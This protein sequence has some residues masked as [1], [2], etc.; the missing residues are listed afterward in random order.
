MAKPTVGIGVIG[1]GLMGRVHTYAWRTIPLLYNG[2]PCNIKLVAVCDVNEQ[3]AE[4]G[5]EQAG[6]FFRTNDY[7]EV[8]NHPEIKVVDICVPN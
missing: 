6:F 4:A 5:R 3:A 8:I 2:E 7:R 1:Y